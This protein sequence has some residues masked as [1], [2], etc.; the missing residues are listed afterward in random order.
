MITLS[1]LKLY[2]D[3]MISKCVLSYMITLSPLKLYTDKMISKCVLSYMITL[4][5]LKLYTDKM[6]S[7]CVLSYMI[8]LSPLKLY[9][10][11]MMGNRFTIENIILLYEGNLN[12]YFTLI[13]II[14]NEKKIKLIL[15]PLHVSTQY[16]YS[17]TSLSHSSIS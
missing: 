10:D 11:K 13:Q 2:T 5:P 4:S 1:P 8:T 14:V 3:K 16:S 9:T 12:E 17:F 7:K 6:I 15:P